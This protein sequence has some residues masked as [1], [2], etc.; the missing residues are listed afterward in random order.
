MLEEG[1]PLET[2]SLTGRMQQSPCFQMYGFHTDSPQP[3]AGLKVTS[4]VL[5]SQQTVM[6][7]WLE[8]IQPCTNVTTF[9]S[10]KNQLAPPPS[11]PHSRCL[12]YQIKQQF[13]VG[14]GH[15][16][17]LLFG[18]LHDLP[19]SQGVQGLVNHPL[20]QSAAQAASATPFFV[21]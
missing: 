9:I 17:T 8:R 3:G 13:Y 5:L 18:V 4:S 1:S 15:F 11:I 10:Q 16:H 20:L 7:G 19:G 21:N 14:W 6:L 2:L 12:I